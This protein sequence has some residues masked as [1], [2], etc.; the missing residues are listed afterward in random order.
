MGS[1]S[2][3]VHRDLRNLVK[4]AHNQGWTLKPTKKGHLQFQA[5]DGI[6]MVLAGGT[7]SDHRSNKNL[8]SRLRKSG[9]DIPRGFK[10]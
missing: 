2:L 9:L 7:P 10:A 5:P 1:M 3:S 8:L 4:L 6:T